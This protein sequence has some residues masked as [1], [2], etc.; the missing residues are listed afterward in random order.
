MKR[1]FKSIAGKTFDVI[2]IGGGIVGAGI[3]RDTTLRGLDTLLLEKED[4]GSGTTSRSTRLIHGGLRYLRQLE[5]GLVRQDLSERE[6]M[7]RIAPHLVHPLS[8]FIPIP[9]ISLNIAMALGTTLYDVVSYDKTLPNHKYLSKNKTLSEEPGLK[10]KGLQCSYVYSDCAIPFTERLNFETAL[11]AYENGA[12]VINHARVSNLLKEGHRVTGVEVKD[13]ISG[14]V[15]QAKGRLVVNATGHWVDSLK[16]MIFKDKPPYLRRTKGVHIMIPSVSRHALVLFSP[17]DGRLFFVIPWQGYSL[18]GTTDTDYRDDLDAVYATREDVD[19]ILEGLH[20]AYPD[21]RIEDV[22]YA[23]AGLRSLALKPGQSASN[24][25]RSHE[26]IDH[27]KSD[28]LNGLVTILGG[29]ITA[30][31]A[32]AKDAADVVCRK[33]GN[34]ARCVT[35]ERQLPGAPALV[36]QEI[37]SLR[38]KER[39]AEDTV[40]HLALLY[41]SKCREVINLASA[42]RAGFEQLSPGGPDIVAQ[43]WYAVKNESCLTVSDFMLRRSVVGLRKDLGIDAVPCVA[44]EMQKLLGWSDDEKNRQIQSHQTTAALALRFRNP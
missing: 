3:A 43:I 21:V 4:F 44:G 10:V 12:T 9:N 2:V 25:S 29:K 28:K 17:V 6:V 24:T 20:L 26:L 42:D 27:S 7:L 19:Y 14:E 13:E 32:V 8:F 37:D 22:F 1:D 38:Q 34:R 16:E 41:G 5:F 18:V 11:S 40:R 23:Y 15:L 30:Y 36:Q 35:A 39:L 31:R 33:L